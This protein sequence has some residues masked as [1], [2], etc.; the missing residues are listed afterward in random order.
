[1]IGMSLLLSI[2]TIACSMQT[3]LHELK[4]ISNGMRDNVIVPVFESI[5]S[6]Y[7]KEKSVIVLRITSR[8]NGHE[9]KAAVLYKDDFK[10]YLVDKKDKLFGFTKYGGVLVLVFG[11]SA[12]EFYQKTRRKET[13]P[14]LEALDY[15]KDTTPAEIEME[16]DMFEPVVWQYSVMKKD[17]EL[18]DKGAFSLLE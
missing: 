15:E 5:D 14:F 1:M 6:E 17:F 18:I 13:F 4:G 8:H 16:A 9:V 7:S 3:E 11:E 10:W 2:L 12:D